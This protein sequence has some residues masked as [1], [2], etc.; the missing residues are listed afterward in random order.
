MRRNS[1][2]IFGFVVSLFVASCST[3][4]LQYEDVARPAPRTQAE[5]N[6]AKQIL[7]DLQNRSIDKNR[8]YCGYIG[9]SP[10]GEFY[11]TTPRRGRKGSCRPK[12]VEAEEELLASYHTHGAYSED[13][14][15]ETP[16]MDDVTSGREEGLDGYI[17][18]PGGRLW[19][20]D[21][22]TGAADLLC[23]LGC[24]IA[25]PGFDLAAEPDVKKTYTRQE[26]AVLDE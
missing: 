17:A 18:T 26:L 8:E 19:F 12:S 20:T 21:G 24:L 23:G 7:N 5:I 22:E 16:S 2:T 6:F 25:D 4:E 10:D 3:G 1:F 9:L 15:S 11:A 14:E 13:F